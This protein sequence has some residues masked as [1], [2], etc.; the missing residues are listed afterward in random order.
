VLEECWWWLTEGLRN[1][2]YCLLLMVG[3]AVAQGTPI[4]LGLQAGM[5]WQQLG[6][7]KPLC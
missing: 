3:T 5:V 1:T 4:R 6:N 2:G 7:C